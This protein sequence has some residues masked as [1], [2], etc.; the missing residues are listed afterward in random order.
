LWQRLFTPVDG[1]PLSPAAPRLAA[2]YLFLRAI[3][4]A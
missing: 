1:A 3:H 2:G 4:N